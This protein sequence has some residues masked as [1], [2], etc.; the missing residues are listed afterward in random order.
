[1]AAVPHRGENFLLE[2]VELTERV[3]ASDEWRSLATLSLPKPGPIFSVVLMCVGDIAVMSLI[4]TDGS[5]TWAFDVDDSIDFG[6]PITTAD[7]FTS[8]ES[9]TSSIVLSFRDRGMQ[10]HY[11][12]FRTEQPPALAGPTDVR[13]VSG[14]EVP[15]GI[16]LAGDQLVDVS[17]LLFTPSAQSDRGPDRLMPVVTQ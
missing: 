17:A 8:A 13:A 7:S 12:W 14:H 1:M 10:G 15:L 6:E 9:T 3:D 5:S 2:S 4:G 16:G 11:L